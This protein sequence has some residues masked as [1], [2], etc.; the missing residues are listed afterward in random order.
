VQGV[1]QV[2]ICTY[3]IRVRRLT[4]GHNASNQTRT[5]VNDPIC[6]VTPEG[7]HLVLGL[8]CPIAPLALLASPA[9]RASINVNPLVV[10][11]LDIGL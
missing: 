7:L 9:L 10:V 3:R 8:I 1:R 11:A 5:R 2:R 6:K 4:E